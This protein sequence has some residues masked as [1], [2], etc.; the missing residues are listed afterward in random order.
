MFFS[1]YISAPPTIGLSIAASAMVA[2]RA[3]ALVAA[4]IFLAFMSCLLGWIKWPPG[5]WAEGHEE[6]RHGGRKSFRFYSQPCWNG[7]EVFVFGLK[8]PLTSRTNARNRGAAGT[9]A[10]RPTA[11]PGGRRAAHLVNTKGPLQAKPPGTALRPA[12]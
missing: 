1:G 4:K 7:V 8:L 12:P 3:S 10:Q 6:A 5:H 2:V 11:P 9:A